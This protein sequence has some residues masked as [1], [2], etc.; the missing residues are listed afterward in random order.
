MTGHGQLRVEAFTPS[1][2]GLFQPSYSPEDRIRTY[3]VCGGVPYYLDRFRDNRP[4]AANL[5]SE[6][7]QRTGSSTTKRS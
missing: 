4:L 1:D 2:A 3:A 7:F 5:L 6:V